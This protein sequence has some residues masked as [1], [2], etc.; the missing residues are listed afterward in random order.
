MGD[1]VP[2]RFE[3]SRS[4]STT[5]DYNHPGI[6]YLRDIGA[7]SRFLGGCRPSRPARPAWRSIAVAV[8]ANVVRYVFEK[9]SMARD[10]IELPTRVF[11]VLVPER[12]M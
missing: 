9:E 11:S 1:F 3:F 4:L 10:R 2:L 5:Y 12:T 7:P 8:L 6:N